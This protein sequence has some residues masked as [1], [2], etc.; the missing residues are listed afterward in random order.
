MKKNG[1][2]PLTDRD[3]VRTRQICVR[4]SLRE[5]ENLQERA[6]HMGMQPATWLRT[7]ALERRLPLAQKPPVPAVN[8]EQYIELARMAANINQLAHAANEKRGF[9]GG[10]VKVDSDLLEQ[11]RA[12][13]VRLRLALLGVAD[14]EEGGGDDY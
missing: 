6:A 13:L 7:A 10:S 14:D 2:P 3:A 11:V 5:W 8:R 9:L 4:L 1:R 12:E